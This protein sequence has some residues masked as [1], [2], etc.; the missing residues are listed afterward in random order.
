MTATPTIAS[1]GAGIDSTA[2]IIELEAQGTPPD[3]VL[4]AETGAEYPETD[5]YIPVFE[6]WLAERQ[7]PFR[8]VRYAPTRLN[9]KPDYRSLLEDILASK[10]LP[11]I[12][13][14]QHS[15]S[16]KWK[17]A[18]QT[19][20]AQLWQPAIDAWAQGS[21]VTRLIGY[22]ASPRDI[23]RHAHALRHD[24][25]RFEN[26]YP[27]IEWG[28]TRE[29]CIERIAAAGL[30]IPRKSSCF[31]CTA[32]SPDDIDSL[33]PDHLGL[34]ILIEAAAAPRLTTTEGL[35]RKSTKGRR[36]PPRPGRISDYIENRG[37][38]PASRIAAIKTRVLSDLERHLA[39]ATRNAASMSEWINQH[40][41]DFDG[42]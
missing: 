5:A 28:W 20:A 3:L 18:P 34:I 7:I 11:A 38:L 21:R 31:M 8:R 4:F 30:P 14:G 1:W 39:P 36:G 10:T 37:L 29:R 2:M 35:W 13:F 17:V 6:D 32:C 33:P 26:R 27:L 9:G 12:A 42:T 24:D 22:D 19:A 25:P 40:F 41:P 15:C 23:R 16:L